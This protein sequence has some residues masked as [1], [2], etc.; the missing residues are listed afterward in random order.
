MN[1]EELLQEIRSCKTLKVRA[2]YSGD[3]KLDAAATM[4]TSSLLCANQAQILDI[5]DDAIQAHLDGKW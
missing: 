1:L 5:L 2:L 4:Y 3:K